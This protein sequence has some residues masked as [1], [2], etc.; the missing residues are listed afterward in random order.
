MTPHLDDAAVRRLLKLETLLP[1]VRQSLVDLSAGRVTQ[2]LRLSMDFPTGGGFVLL[3]PAL[4]GD[5]LVT[6]IITMRPDNA[7]RGIPTLLATLVLMDAASGETLAIMDATWIT[8]L[9]TAAAS[10]VAAEALTP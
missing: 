8:E 1:A 5:T 2:P 10:A 4:A 6:K 7:M 9:R 3:K